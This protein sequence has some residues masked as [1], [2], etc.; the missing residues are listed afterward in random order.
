VLNAAMLSIHA[1]GQAYAK[2]AKT[3]PKSGVKQ[4]DRFLSSDGAWLDDVMQ[5]DTLRVTLACAETCS[6]SGGPL[7]FKI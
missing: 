4:I 1:I 6:T 2:L 5:R 3:L 7:R